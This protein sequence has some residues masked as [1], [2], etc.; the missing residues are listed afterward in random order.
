MKKYTSDLLLCIGSA[1]IVGGVALIY[2]P[3]SLIVCGLFLIGFAYL[4][5]REKA[6]NA[7]VEKPGE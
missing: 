5:E 2:I 6:Q 1:C 3:A 7:P 4:S